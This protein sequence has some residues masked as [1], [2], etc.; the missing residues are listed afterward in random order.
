MGNLSF[1]KNLNPEKKQT[2]GIVD[3]VPGPTVSLLTPSLE[4]ANLPNA[5]ARNL[6]VNQL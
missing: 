6:I 4:M 5:E 2:K 3:S 1:F